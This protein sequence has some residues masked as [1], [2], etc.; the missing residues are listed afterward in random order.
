MLVA[1]LVAKL[2]SSM[3][4]EK[5]DWSVALLEMPLDHYSVAMTV[6]QLAGML[7]HLRVGK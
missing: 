2:V 3:V 1:L 4:V 6:V 5:A 7:G